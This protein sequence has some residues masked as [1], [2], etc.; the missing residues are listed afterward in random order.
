L[1][2]FAVEDGDFSDLRV[3]GLFAARYP[4]ATGF[5]RHGLDRLKLA[6][7]RC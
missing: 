3:G 2:L 4:A 5:E 1:L 7:N 6:T